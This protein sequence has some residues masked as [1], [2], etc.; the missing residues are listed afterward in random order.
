MLICRF[1]LFQ[2]FEYA[3][4]REILEEFFWKNFCDNYLEICKVRSYGLSAEK[5]A[6]LDLTALNK[7]EILKNQLSA[8]ATLSLSLKNIL[9]LFAPFVPHLTEELY[10]IIFASEFEKFKSIHARHNCAKLSLKKHSLIS[11]IN[12]TKIGENLL[13]IIF[14][15]RKFKSEKNLSMKSTISLIELPKSF[16]ITGIEDDILNVCN[17]QKIVLKNDLSAINII[18]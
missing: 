18:E 12:T 15:V 1:E 9:K 11:Q 4:A 3:K 7:Q 16:D 14:V 13:E 6:G 10:S 8:I 5:L 17:A 2:Q